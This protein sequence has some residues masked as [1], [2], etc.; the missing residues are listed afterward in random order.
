MK[1]RQ[2]S[3]G[4]FVI[5]QWKKFVLQMGIG[6]C[7][8][9]AKPIDGFAAPPMDD[10]FQRVEQREDMPKILPDAGKS[11][12]WEMEPE[13]DGWEEEFTDTDSRRGILAVRG[14]VFQGF[15]GQV[16][17]V[18]KEVEGGRETV[19]SLHREGGYIAN[20]ELRPGRYQVVSVEADSDGRKFDSHVEAEELVV[21]TDRVTM[22]QFFVNPGSVYQVT[23]ETEGERQGMENGD[24]EVGREPALE[25]MEK[26]VNKQGEKES[27]LTEG[28]S[29][30]EEQS[31]MPIAFMAAVF[32]T[33]ISLYGAVWMIRKH[34][35]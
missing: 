20:Q 9:S 17:L 15:G 2:N 31:G 3:E 21:D 7:I 27:D 10:R 6:L 25:K 5:R 1:R 32:G 13:A 33:V 16:Q 11:T 26:Q 8:C 14:E 23:Y 24:K 12:G 19:I 18:V 29:S 4:I 34:R 30:L 28:S 22:C 35:N